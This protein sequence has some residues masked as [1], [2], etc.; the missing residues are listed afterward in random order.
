[1]I[2]FELNGREP[3]H[4][5]GCRLQPKLGRT[6]C[7]RGCQLTSLPDRQRPLSAKSTGPARAELRKRPVAN[8]TGIY[9]SVSS[10]EAKERLDRLQ[11]AIVAMFEKLNAALERRINFEFSQ[12]RR[13]LVAE[14]LARFDAIF[15]LNQDLLLELHYED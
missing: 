10:T 14:F 11:T 7:E 3:Y 2:R 4:A 12:E 5:S 1:M 13:F 9:S 6:A 15:G 8:P